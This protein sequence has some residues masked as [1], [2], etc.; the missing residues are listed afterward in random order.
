MSKNVQTGKPRPKWPI[1]LAIFVAIVVIWFPKAAVT[2][3]AHGASFR[4]TNIGLFGGLNRASLLMDNR[5]GSPEAT[6][7]RKHSL[8]AWKAELER[9]LWM[10]R[11]PVDPDALDVKQSEKLYESRIKSANKDA[12]KDF[13]PPWFFFMSSTA[14]FISDIILTLLILCGPLIVSLFQYLFANAELA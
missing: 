13:S 5:E 3:G 2:L 4:V 6:E 7:S 14:R 12:T 11:L 8:P 10:S 1:A 9:A